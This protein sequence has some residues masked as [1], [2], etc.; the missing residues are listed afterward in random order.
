MPWT[1]SSPMT[2]RLKFIARYLQLDTT[3]GRV[4]DLDERHVD[5]GRPLLFE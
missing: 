5:H 2:E 3:I 4:D 1:E